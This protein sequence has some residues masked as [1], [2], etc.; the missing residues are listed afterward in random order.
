MLLS[1]NQLQNLAKH[2]F[3]SPT[4]LA[5]L[6]FQCKAVKIKP[7]LMVRDVS[8]RWNSTASMVERALQ[9]REALKL[10]VVME[11]HNRPRGARLGHFKLS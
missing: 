5:D 1:V 8:T 2:I 7:V 10:L 6:E 3:N 11:Q 4:I 9:L